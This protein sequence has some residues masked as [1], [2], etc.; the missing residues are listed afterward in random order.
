MRERDKVRKSIA[1]HRL[2]GSE[3]F[4]RE[5]GIAIPPDAAHPLL[6]SAVIEPLR[7]EFPEARFRVNQER[8]EGL[9]YYQSFTLRISPEAP[10]GNRYPVVDGGFTDWTA[11]LR[12]NQKER[13]LISGIGSEFVCKTYRRS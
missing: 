2:G 11:R 6:E 8:L 5:L 3:R 13:L 1:A 4:F 10:D 7:P 9:G 12:G